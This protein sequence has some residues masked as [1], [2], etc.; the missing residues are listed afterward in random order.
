MMGI[1]KVKRLLNNG[2]KRDKWLTRSEVKGPSQRLL[3]R[4]WKKG[5]EQ[6]EAIEE[7][8]KAKLSAEEGA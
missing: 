4:Q 8:E 2:I 5:Q 1:G 3:R 6:R 7:R